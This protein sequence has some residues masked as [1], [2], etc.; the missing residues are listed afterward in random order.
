MSKSRIFEF[1]GSDLRRLETWDQKHREAAWQKRYEI[2]LAEKRTKELKRTRKPASLAK[3]I[4]DYRKIRGLSRT[5]SPILAG[6]SDEALADSVEQ[7]FQLLQQS[8]ATGNDEQFDQALTRVTEVRRMKANGVLDM[9]R[10]RMAE[11]DP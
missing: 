6:D 4:T 8:Y 10:E 2:T 5:E 1:G 9:I 11:P 3:G 7:Q